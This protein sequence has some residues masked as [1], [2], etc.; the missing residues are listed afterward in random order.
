LNNLRYEQR[1]LRQLQT[2]TIVNSHY[3]NVPLGHP[4]LPTHVLSGCEATDGLS[5]INVYEDGDER[6]TNM[7]T[8]IIAAA[9]VDAN[10]ARAS[11]TSPIDSPYEKWDTSLAPTATI[12]SLGSK[13]RGYEGIK[14]S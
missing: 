9:R 6:R 14:G 7:R 10:P 5:N 12:M 2:I 3:W 11:R 4:E 8:R 13:T 1:N